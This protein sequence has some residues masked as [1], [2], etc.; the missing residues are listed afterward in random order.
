MRILASLGNLLP[1]TKSGCSA[2]EV[3]HLSLLSLLPPSCLHS[4]ACLTVSHI[5]KHPTLDSWFSLFP[6]PPQPPEFP[7]FLQKEK[8]KDQHESKDV[9]AIPFQR[10]SRFSKGVYECR[11]RVCVGSAISRLFRVDYRRV[12]WWRM[13]RVGEV[14]GWRMWRTVGCGGWRIGGWVEDG[15]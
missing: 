13:W 6:S 5:C 2:K 1:H 9:K 12:F 8:R 10:D 4:Y 3:C 14:E 7:L 11:E 15:G